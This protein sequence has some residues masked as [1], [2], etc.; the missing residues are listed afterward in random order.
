MG[1]DDDEYDNADFSIDIEC[2]F[3]D[4]EI[5]EQIFILIMQHT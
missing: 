2:E 4:H 5:R 3:V 1:R